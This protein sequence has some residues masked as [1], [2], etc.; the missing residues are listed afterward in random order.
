MLPEAELRFILD[1][2]NCGALVLDRSLNI[3]YANR[4]MLINSGRHATDD[5]QGSVFEAFPELSRDWVERHSKVVFLL[6]QNSFSGW[7]QRPHIFRFKNRQPLTADVAL[8]CQDCTF[9]PVKD[10]KG[11]VVAVC[12]LVTDVTETSAYHGRLTTALA[13]LQELS[14]R[15]ALTQVFNR[16]QIERFANVEFDRFRRYGSPLSVAMVD[17]DHFKSFN[18]THGHLVGDE[19]LRTVAQAL[20][21]R[22]RSTDYVGRYGGE[23]FL[24]VLPGI[25]GFQAGQA[26]EAFRAVVEGLS[27]QSEGKQLRATVSIGTS[28]AKPQHPDLSALVREADEALYRAKEMG[29]NRVVQAGSFVPVA[30]G[31]S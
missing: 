14:I 3:R 5:L 12:I 17:I 19:V 16:R 9:L 8:M 21:K 31:S 22:V 26:G 6:K 11:T 25:K 2:L 1:R 30:G 10:A 23:E 29:R 27:I 24:M 4:F 15:D 13:E 18:D 28:E 20:A 7:Q